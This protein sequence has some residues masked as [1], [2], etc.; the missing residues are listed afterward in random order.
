MLAERGTPAGRSTHPGP[1]L[2]FNPLG[3]PKYWPRSEQG[4]RAL[5]ILSSLG[6]STRATPLPDEKSI[7]MSS[8][9]RTS[10]SGVPATA[11]VVEIV[12]KAAG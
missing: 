1:P 3:A 6:A 10:E 12:E 4:K 5:G 11:E 8:G 7:A 9:V 2:E